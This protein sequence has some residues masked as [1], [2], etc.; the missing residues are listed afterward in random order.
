MPE[1]AIQRDPLPY[2]DALARREPASIDTVVI[3]CTEL[4]DLATAR[5]YGERVLYPSGAGNSGHY[6]IDRDGSTVEYVPVTY[7][8]HHTRRWNPRS[9]G[10]ELVNT[11]RFP[12]WLDSRRQA[13][14]EPYTEAQLI[15]LMAL[16]GQLKASLPALRQIAGHEDLDTDEVDASDDP[17]LKVRRKRDPGPLFP[18]DAVLAAVPLQRIR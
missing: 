2:L 9:V 3:H 13:M 16:L 12:D 15:A 6:Y 17:S 7:V 18:W 10:I 4:P 8:A 14:D 1:P 5:D 11:G